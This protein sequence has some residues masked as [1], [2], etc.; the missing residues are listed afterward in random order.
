VRVY[1]SLKLFVFVRLGSLFPLVHAFVV[2][3]DGPT[4]LMCV[5]FEDVILK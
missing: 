2:L 4:C 1:F 5:S 3:D